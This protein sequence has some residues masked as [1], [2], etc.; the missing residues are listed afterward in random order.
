VD[1]NGDKKTDILVFNP[2]DGGYAKWYSDG[3]V[4]PDFNY[5]PIRY[6]AGKPGFW[7]NAKLIPVD[8]NG[9]GKTDIL[10][11]NP[12]DG[13]YAKWY[14][15]GTVGPDFNY[16]PIRYIG[17]KPG[18]WPNAQLIPLDFNGD[19]KTDILVFNPSDGGYVKWY[20][21]GTV[22]PDFNY[23]PIRYIGGKPGFWTNVQLISVDF[24]KDGK[25]DILVFHPSDGGFAKW[26]GI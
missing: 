10:V 2:S 19:K 14:S 12:K 6:I 26:Y 7:T 17:G 15:D 20:S 25:I 8:F 18:F 13:G 16:Q 21:D 3:T 11:F 1:F 22:G 24:N 4:G 9:D 5:Q 23:Q